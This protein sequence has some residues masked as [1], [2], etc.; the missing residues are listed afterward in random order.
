M[1]PSSVIAATTAVLTAGTFAAAA[2]G[3]GAGEQ[4]QDTH[5]SH[6]HETMHREHMRNPEMR[7]MHREHMRNPEMRQMHR[8][9]MRNPEMRQ[10][11][12]EC[13]RDAEMQQMHHDMMSSTE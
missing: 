6:A 4:T 1:L 7:Q 11:H 10:M 13:M 2:T 5:R 9:H 3:D 12:R 8:E